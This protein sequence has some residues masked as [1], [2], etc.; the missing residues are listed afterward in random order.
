LT[1]DQKRANYVVK[2]RHMMME[3]HA[4]LLDNEAALLRQKYK[5]KDR[6]ERMPTLEEIVKEG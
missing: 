1:E 4:Q 2:Y 3:R 5:M 6:I